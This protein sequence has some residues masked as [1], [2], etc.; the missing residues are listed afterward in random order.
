M[1]APSA[2]PS[3]PPPPPPLPPPPPPPP[4]DFD[5]LSSSGDRADMSSV[6]AELNKGEAITSGLKKVDKNQMTHKNPNLRNSGIVSDVGGMNTSFIIIFFEIIE[7]S[8]PNYIAGG[9]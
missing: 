5:A 9:N 7:C 4:T 6:F 3:G 2:P 8:F 1:P